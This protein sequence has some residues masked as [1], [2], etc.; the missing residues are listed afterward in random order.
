MFPM[1]GA[2]GVG[3]RVRTPPPWKVT[4]GT[5]FH[6][7]KQYDHPTHPP[8]PPLEKLD[9]FPWILFSFLWIRQLDPL[10]K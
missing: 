4:S 8:P 6:W 5:G 7:I 2:R 9:S 3:Q 1:G 10:C